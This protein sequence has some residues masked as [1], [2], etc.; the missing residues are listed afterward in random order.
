MRKTPR[1]STPA[2]AWLRAIMRA[3][4]PLL[5][6]DFVGRIE[7]HVF[8]GGIANINLGQSFRDDGDEGKA[9]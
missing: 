2:P 9:D 4:K 8:R 7:I 6:R 5:P 3:V 1:Q